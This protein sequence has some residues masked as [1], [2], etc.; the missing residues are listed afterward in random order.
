ME[1]SLNESRQNF[2][3]DKGGHM[4]SIFDEIIDRRGTNCSKH[5]FKTENGYMESVL[6]LW[7]ADM[8]FRAPKEVSEAVIN[9]GKHGIFGY[10]DINSGYYD[11]AVSWYKKRFRVELKN[12]W[13][14]TTP[15]IVFAVCCAMT[16]FTAPGDGVL[17][18]PPVYYPFKR[19]ISMNGRV[20]I[21]N[22]LR[23]ENGKYSIDFE[24]FEA[25]LKGGNVKLFVLCNPHNPVGRVWREDELS[26]MVELC[27]K[28]NVLI[29]SDEIHSDFIIPGYTHTMLNAITKKC[30]VA[31]APSKTFNIAGMQMSNI[32]IPDEELRRKFL[33]T[34]DCTGAG[35][36]N[37]AGLAAAQAAY[38]Y[39]E[40]W[41]DDVYA[42]ILKNL[43]IARDILKS[44]A[45]YAK[46]IEPEG[47][48]LIWV[49]F[50]ELGLNDTEL[51]KLI[52]NEANLWLDMGNMFGEEGE[53]F[54]RINIASS[55]SVINK[56]MED[57]ASAVINKAKAMK[58]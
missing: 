3:T 17:I 4:N 24:D 27:D 31:T 5:D 34:R 36:P 16:S 2:T 28:Y 46:L 58:K 25:K 35:A 20:P 10:T 26:R 23:Y 11:A 15:G 32:I 47:T 30:I 43:D 1:N 38:K 42:Y 51:E 50:S 49:D 13:I 52:V 33:H 7:I 37:I 44:A 56:A 8:D 14:V 19:S 29:F 48:F 12:E 41:F 57:L 9:V 21:N 22:P 54:A 53:G 6:S 18:Q 39:G 45:P 55:A 40:G